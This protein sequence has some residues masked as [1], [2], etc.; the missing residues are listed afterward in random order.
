MVHGF[1]SMF[2]SGVESVKADTTASKLT[3]IGKVDPSKIR[4]ILHQKTKKKVDII[5][6]QPKKEDSNAKNNKG[7]NKKSSDKK[8]DAENKKPKEVPLL[9]LLI[10]DRVPIEAHFTVLL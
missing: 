9:L 5:S 10:N 8:P 2:T 3:V 4:E 1:V 6:P 7:D